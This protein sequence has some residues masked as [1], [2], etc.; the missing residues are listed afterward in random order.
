MMRLQIQFGRRCH[1][2]CAGEEAMIINKVCEHDEIA[3]RRPCP[4]HND[5][6]REISNEDNKQ[7]MGT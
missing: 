2:H 6:C 5:D 3:M 7:A 4:A 1:V